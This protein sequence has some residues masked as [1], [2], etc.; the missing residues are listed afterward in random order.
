MERCA[1]VGSLL[2]LPL[3]IERLHK[4]TE[5][6]VVSNT[7]IKAALDIKEMPVRAEDG[8]RKTIRS[9]ETDKVAVE[10]L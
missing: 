7:R 9:F 4:L 2:H 10:D 8:L 3:N 6:F 1:G 5:N